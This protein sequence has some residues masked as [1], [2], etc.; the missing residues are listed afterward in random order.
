LITSDNVQEYEADVLVIGSGA[1]G[2]R[3]SI[4][5]RDSGAS[6]LLLSKATAGLASA[7][8]L[9]YGAFAS[10]GL[11]QSAEEHAQKTLKTGYHRNNS[12]LVQVLA[13][14]APARISELRSRGMAITE[15]RYGFMARGRFPIVGRSIVEALLTW[16][17]TS[18]VRVV[19][20]DHG[21]KPYRRP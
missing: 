16:A 13:E 14:E 20:L 5:A 9:S 12:R 1:A 4:A 19:G 17:R 6:V 18:R 7:T 3:A 21:R 8:L 15:G 10:A 2:L 11:V